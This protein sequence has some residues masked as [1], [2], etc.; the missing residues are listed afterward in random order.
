LDR[1]RPLPS[2]NADP[3]EIQVEA[4]WSD[5]PASMN[6][7]DPDPSQLNDP[8]FLA[9]LHQLPQ[10]VRPDGRDYD[11]AAEAVTVEELANQYRHA[12]ARKL[13]RLY[14]QWQGEQR[15][16]QPPTRPAGGP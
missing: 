1:A 16:P 6:T 4:R 2:N 7:S 15:L 8:A 11:L 5:W 12:Q 10:P 13:L 9:W 3:S 14:R